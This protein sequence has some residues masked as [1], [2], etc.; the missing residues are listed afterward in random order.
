MTEVALLTKAVSS[1]VEVTVKVGGVVMTLD[2]DD[3][4]D[5]LE[6]D[7]ELLSETTINNDSENLTTIMTSKQ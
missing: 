2:G 3:D 6:S 1:E 5:D 7:S 4:D